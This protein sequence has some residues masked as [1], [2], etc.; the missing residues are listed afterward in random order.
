MPEAVASLVGGA[1]VTVTAAVVVVTA[2]T[3]DSVAVV[4]KL[5]ATSAVPAVLVVAVKVA[6]CIDANTCRQRNCS[7]RRSLED[8]KVASAHSLPQSPGKY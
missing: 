8:S 3:G 5:V 1:E 2:V 4:G 7:H 6:T